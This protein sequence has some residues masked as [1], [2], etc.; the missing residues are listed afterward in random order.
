MKITPNSE[1]APQTKMI[2]ALEFPS[3]QEAIA[4]P[5]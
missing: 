3:A 2:V 4:Y 5:K 1:I